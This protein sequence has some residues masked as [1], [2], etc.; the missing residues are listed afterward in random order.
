MTCS[1]IAAREGGAPA[2]AAAGAVLVV[3]VDVVEVVVDV[4]ARSGRPTSVN[5]E[6]RRTFI[7]LR[8]A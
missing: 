7:T 5:A 1:I 6:R 8:Y 2:G 3:E 4:W